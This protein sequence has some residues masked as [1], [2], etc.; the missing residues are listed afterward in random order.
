MNGIY[1]H[2]SQGF[3]NLWCT[4]LGGHD[5]DYNRRCIYCGRSEVDIVMG[6]NE[7][8]KETYWTTYVEVDVR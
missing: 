4:N 6:K 3:H 7:E 2:I 5:I 8:Y 1:K